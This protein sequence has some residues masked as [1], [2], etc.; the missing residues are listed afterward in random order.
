MNPIYKHPFIRA[1]DF[2][3]EELLDL[4]WLDVTEARR[5]YFMS[6][7]PRSYVYGNGVGTREY[8]SKPLAGCVKSIMQFLNGDFQSSYNICFLNRYDNQHQHLGWHADD[9]PSMDQG[10]PIAVVSLGVEREIW[11]KE[12]EHKGVVPKANRRLLEHGSLFIM[13]AGFQ[14]SYYHRIPK[15]DRECGTRIS[16]T[17]RRYV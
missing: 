11:W 2:A 8:H 1:A 10:H 6:D 5:E 17:F 13:P 9:S 4:E 15:C 16:L 3:L 7:T 14:D 12:K